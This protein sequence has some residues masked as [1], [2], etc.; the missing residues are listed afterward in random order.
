M[1]RRD[2]ARR[3]VPFH[4]MSRREQAK[5]L[6]R[7]SIIR[8]A[9]ELIQETHEAGF[10]MRALALRAGVSVVTPYNLF[11]SKQAILLTLLD[12]DI[13]SFRRTLDDVDADE[14]DRLFNAVSLGREFFGSEP[15]YYRTVLGAVY[16]SGGREYRA[17]FRGPRRAFWRELVDNAIGAGFL[18]K[19]LST[20]PFMTNLVSIFFSEIMEWVMGEISLAEMDARVQ[21]GFGLAMLGVATPKAKRRLQ[22]RV[23]QLQN[24]LEQYR[25]KA[26][27]TDRAAV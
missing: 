5:Q 14:L 11:G 17:M 4:D 10:S 22:T 25:A 15:D 1:V 12:A 23:M 16:G 7:D 19:D 27:A 2:N 18:S 21:Y 9:R 3:W 20:E 13:A 8:A 26:T 24:A 6:R